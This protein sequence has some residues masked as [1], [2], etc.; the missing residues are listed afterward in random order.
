MEQGHL[1]VC[2]EIGNIMK[3]PDQNLAVWP[4]NEFHVGSAFNM[5]MGF[6]ARRDTHNAVKLMLMGI[7]TKKKEHSILIPRIPK[8]II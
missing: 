7:T 5:C 8:V 2:H 6:R 4:H 3:F 1:S